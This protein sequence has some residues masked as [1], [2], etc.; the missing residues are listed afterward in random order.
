VADR[1][2]LPD[3]VRQT[4][5]AAEPAYELF[6]AKGRIGV[7]YE[8][9]GH[10]VTSGD[11]AAL[12]DFFDARLRGKPTSRPF[13]RYPTDAERETAIAAAAKK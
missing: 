13:D 1:I 11:W 9:H 2:S 3:A 5:R 6:G 10:T 4:V 12:M 8:P 7:S